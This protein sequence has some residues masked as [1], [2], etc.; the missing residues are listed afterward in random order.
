MDNISLVSLIIGLAVGVIAASGILL[1]VLK[2]KGID[3]GMVLEQA[4]NTVGVINNTF[5]SLKTLLPD[6]P[7]INIIDKIL[8]WASIGVEQAE[9]LYLIGK[10][11]GEERKGAAIDFIHESLTLAGIEITPSIDK[12]I[13]GAVEASVLALG[14]TNQIE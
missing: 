2:K 3:A 12:I 5:D 10:I 6:N 7:A 4:S 8:D 1:P 13:D 14:H 9:Q 11:E